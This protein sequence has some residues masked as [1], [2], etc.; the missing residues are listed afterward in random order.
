[1]K[2]TEAFVAEILKIEYIKDF[3]RAYDNSPMLQYLDK[4]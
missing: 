2:I 4:K 3:Q 1:M